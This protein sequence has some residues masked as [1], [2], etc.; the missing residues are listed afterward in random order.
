MRLHNRDKVWPLVERARDLA[1]WSLGDL[2]RHL[3]GF[4][5][6][7]RPSAREATLHC[8]GMSRGQL[9]EAILSYEFDDVLGD[10]PGTWAGEPL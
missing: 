6:S 1:D 10:E 7:K 9:I 4:N 3:A 5:N 2:R 8:A